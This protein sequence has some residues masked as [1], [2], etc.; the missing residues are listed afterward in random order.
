MITLKFQVICWDIYYF[1]ERF[2]CRLSKNIQTFNKFLVWKKFI[3]RSLC[4]G[5]VAEIWAVVFFSSTYFGEISIFGLSNDPA[6]RN[7]STLMNPE[8]FL[9]L[10]TYLIE[11]E[12]LSV[13]LGLEWWKITFKV[14]WFFDWILAFP[15]QLIDRKF[16]KSREQLRNQTTRKL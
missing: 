7:W 4:T 16:Q 11:G 5:G 9:I 2:R 12:L 3:W 10:V 15:K 8:Q 6:T 1:S 13:W 14:F